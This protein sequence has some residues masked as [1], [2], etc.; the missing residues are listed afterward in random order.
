VRLKELRKIV[1]KAYKSAGE[2][3][4]AEF[5]EWFARADKARALRNDYVHARWGVP[6]KY[7][8]GPDCALID[9]IPLLTVLSLTWDMSPNQP[10]KSTAMTL[11][12]F[13]Q[14]VETV[15]GLFADYWKL[16]KTY[17]RFA[18]LGSEGLD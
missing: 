1:L 8:G 5:E 10:D 13:A 11:D 3:A 15:E 12:E 14:Q 7:L 18:R 6:G 9:A 17:E 2:T 16:S 4:L